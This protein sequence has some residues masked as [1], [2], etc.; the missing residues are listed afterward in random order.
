[1]QLPDLDELTPR[2]REILVLIGE[3]KSLMDI[4][5]TLYRSLKTIESHRL[6]LGKKL[7]AS[8]R[9]DLA[10][11]AIA[12]GLVSL[13]KPTDG[14]KPSTPRA[15]SR[16]IHDD[17]VAQDWADAILDRIYDR[18]GADY[19]N[20][21]ACAFCDVLG[22]DHAG[23][24]VP[25]HDE[26]GTSM[27][28][29]LAYSVRGKIGDQFSYEIVNTPC[30]IALEQDVCVVPSGAIQR[31]PDDDPL[32]KLGA[33]SYAGVCLRDRDG[34]PNGILWLIDNKPLEQRD[35]I[36]NLLMHFEARASPVV[37]DIAR[38]RE[39]LRM[40]ERHSEQL[41]QANRELQVHNEQLD[42]IATYYIGL[43]ERMSDGLIVL[44]PA[45][46]IKYVNE[47][48]SEIADRS[49]DTLLGMTG[50]ELLTP[51][52]QETFLA[53]QEKRQTD[54]MQHYNAAIRL[55]SGG[56][57]EVLVS[58]RTLFH[59]DGTFA[60]SFAVVTDHADVQQA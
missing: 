30:Q 28:R 14:S 41:A 2:E 44:D 27:F 1:M 51:E 26:D 22:V 10:K 32:G 36:V 43:T 57:R 46:R 33:E 53:M 23:V 9:V 31:F 7:G 6:S 39:S 34:G 37:A 42:Q 25:D 17:P 20:E 35:S 29:S 58:P 59:P 24:C 49:R 50:V 48:F 21:M 18:A 19:L 56:E 4:A 55:P 8:N 3:G 15:H 11:I 12:H 38:T 60:G 40:L 47:K 5:Q 52:S 16:A 13:P 45:W 54:Q